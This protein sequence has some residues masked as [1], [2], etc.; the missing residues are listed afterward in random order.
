LWICQVDATRP[1]CHIVERGFLPCLLTFALMDFLLL[2][3]LRQ[4]LQ[5]RR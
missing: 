2:P 3:W 5:R 1:I 4:R